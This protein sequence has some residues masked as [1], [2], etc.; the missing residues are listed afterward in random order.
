MFFDELYQ[1]P[2]CQEFLKSKLSQIAK[3]YAKPI[4]SCHYLGQIPGIRGELKAAN[5]SYMLIAGCDKMNYNELKEEL[6]PYTLDDLLHLKR[7]HS[8]NLVKTS[9]GYARFITGLPKP[10]S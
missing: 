4:I 3:F 1:T 7:Y 6:D 8:L 10:I 5:T 9:D 2:N